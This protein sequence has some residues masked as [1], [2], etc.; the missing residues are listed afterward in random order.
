M[1]SG[2]G[3]ASPA[4][5]G[6][7]ELRLRVLSAIVMVAV[8]LGTLVA[9][10]WPF[11]VVWTGIA[12]AVAWEWLRL[13]G[14]A[15]RPVAL[16]AVAVLVALGALLAAGRSDLAPMAAGAGFLLLLSAGEGVAGRLWGL[17]GFLY[18][19]VLLVAMLTLRGVGPA[20]LFLVAWMFAVVWSTDIAAFFVGRTL[21]GPK[22]WPRVSPKKTWSGF[23]GGLLA[24]VAAGLGVAA[25]ARQQGAPLPLDG[26][27]L[28]LATA[29]ASIAGQGG[30]LAESALKRRFA[31]KDSGHLIP[32]HGGFLDRIDAFWAVAALTLAAHA[33]GGI[34]R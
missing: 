9:G 25:L 26:M 28:A 29:L 24:G 5:G 20:G 22:L 32:G 33:A 11:A 16:G 2:Q 6:S 13:T 17:A 8:A 34:V 4:T 3:S 10:G 1:P 31:V 14:A 19:A 21:G 12:A 30:D 7:S 18:A 27:A 23:L 15:R